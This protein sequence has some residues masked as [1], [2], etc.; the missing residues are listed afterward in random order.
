MSYIQPT[1]FVFL[2]ELAENNNRDWF[3]ANKSR[4]EAEVREPLL[5]FIVDFGVWG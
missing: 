4:Y 2:R 1:L 5:R 3:Q